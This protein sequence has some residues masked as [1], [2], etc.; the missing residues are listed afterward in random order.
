MILACQKFLGQ[1]TKVLRLRRPPPPCWE[2][3]PNNPVIFFWVLPLVWLV[4]CDVCD[5]LWPA[6]LDC[7][8]DEE[9]FQFYPPFKCIFINCN[10][11]LLWSSYTLSMINWHGLNTKGRHKKK[12]VFFSEKLRKGGEESR[13]IRNFLI[14][15]NWDFFG[16]FFWKGGGPTYS[17]RVLS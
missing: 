1:I 2:K 9:Q 10:T 14:R 11:R 5:F 7:Y 15:K 3:F 6:Y 4:Y 13:R 17:K 12:T 16:I 8:P